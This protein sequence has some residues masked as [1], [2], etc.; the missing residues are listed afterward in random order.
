LAFQYGG[1]GD[2]LDYVVRPDISVKPEEED[3]SD[4]YDTVYIDMTARAPH[5]GLAFL[6]DRNNVWEIVSNIFGKHS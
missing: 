1:T 5:T 4:G 3:L 6:D 2:T